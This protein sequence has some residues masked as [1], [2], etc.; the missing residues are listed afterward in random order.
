MICIP[1]LQETSDE[2]CDTGSEVDALQKEF[3][4]KPVDFSLVNEGWN[5]NKGKFS[6]D[7]KVVEARA[8]EVREWLKA[9]PEK[10]IVVVTHGGFLHFFTEDWS[11]T[12]RF[13]GMC[14]IFW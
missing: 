2:P 1:E 13:A 6:P 8:Q 9:R 7:A 14:T 11:D 3:D 4:G 12:A 10:E 5:S